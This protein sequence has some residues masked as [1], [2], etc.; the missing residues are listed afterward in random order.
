[1]MIMY[2]C[3]KCGKEYEPQYYFTKRFCT[4]GSHL[5]YR[6][7]KGP[8]VRTFADKSS[9]KA[10]TPPDIEKATKIGRILLEEFTSKRG[11]FKDY[12]MP[13]YVLPQ[14]EE[15]SRELAL[16]YTYIT[17]LDK[18][19]NADRLWANAVKVYNQNP[20]KFT[21]DQILA[22]D[23]LTL[24]ELIKSIGGRYPGNQATAWRT[25]SKII[26]EKYNGDP[27]KITPTPLSLREIIRKIDSFPELRGE[28][29]SRLYLRI[30]GE[31]GLLKISDLKEL[32]V[33]VDVQVKKFTY[34]TGV[35][36]GT[37]NLSGEIT[38]RQ[39]AAVMDVWK[40]A[41]KAIGCG[42]YQLDQPIWSMASR[43][44]KN[45][46][47]NLCPVEGLC[48]KRFED[49]P[50][51]SSV[52]LT[53]LQIPTSDNEKPNQNISPGEIVTINEFTKITLENEGYIVVTDTATGARYHKPNC[54]FITHSNFR[55]KVITN[56]G[57]NGS[58][59]WVKSL[60]EALQ[61]KAKPCDTCKP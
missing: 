29:L 32:D 50:L 8:I 21:P 46:L 13:E 14:A 6:P 28:K 59:Y 42:P 45:K 18:Q 35:L 25:I 38:S 26:L 16:Y 5:E 39:R 10:T 15:G 36:R 2:I 22:L 19:T 55:K 34:Y 48:E 60:K 37:H 20:S 43:L 30:M 31:K 23:K 27:R 58:Y 52:K 12:S 56:K 54:R 51:E 41:S 57:K 11:I 61:H 7:Y 44:C 33:A 40:R 49:N 1:M 24:E 53:K 9:E 4:C 3:P 17:S 47:C